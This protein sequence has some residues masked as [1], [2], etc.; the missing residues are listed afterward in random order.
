MKPQNKEFLP[1]Y[2]RVKNGV[3]SLFKV[4]KLK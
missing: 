4:S 1:F 2:D 3:L